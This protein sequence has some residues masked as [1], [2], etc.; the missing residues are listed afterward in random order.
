MADNTRS[1]TPDSSSSFEADIK[2][3]ESPPAPPA[4]VQDQPELSLAEQAVLIEQLAL[5][6]G[7]NHKRLML[8]ADLCIVPAICLLYLLAFL[9]RVNISNANIYGLSKDLHLHGNQY[10]IALTVFFVPYI[11]SEVPSNYFLKK[12]KPHIWLSGCMVLFGAAAMC[13]GAVQTFGGLVAC[14]FF[15]GMFEAGMFPGCFYLLSMWY[16]REEAQKRYSFFF[17]STCLAGAF[18]GLIAAGIW[19]LD[20]SR[21]IA[22]WRWIFI[23]E[24][25]ITVV[26]S[27]IMYFFISDFPEDAKWLKPNERAF[28]KAKLALDSGESSH[29]IKLNPKGVLVVFKEWKVW[30]AGLLYFFLIIPAYSYA[31]FAAAIVKSLGYSSIQTQFH[32]VPPWVAAFGFSMILAVL[33]DRVRHR[34]LFVVFSC[35]VAIA[36]FIMLLA[37]KTNHNVRYAG[38]FL[39]ASGL[40][41]AMPILVCWT[42]MNFAGHH[43][44]AVGTGWQIGFG[45]IG[46]IIA[47]F[48]FLTKDSPYYVKGLAVGLGSTALCIVFTCVYAYGMFLENKAKRQGKQDA[49]WEAM[50]DDQRRVAGDLRPSFVY[51]Y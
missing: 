10:N 24:G 11:V 35:L 17:S 9:D 15:L 22:G 27:A 18:S 25:A 4:R 43:R 50:T 31:Y 5:E 33:S 32:S 44:R 34:F 20:G 45:N 3:G 7:V 36:G 51:N 37:N 14:R 41:T 28:M 12:L 40:Y 46:G 23:I 29:D 1:V 6:H 39:T 47:T 16:R 49:R 21:G 26:C 42:N 8:K 30:M 48:L 38:L 19:N 13:Q 2:N